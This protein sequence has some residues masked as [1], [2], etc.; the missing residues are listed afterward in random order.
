MTRRGESMT[1]A[2]AAFSDCVASILGSICARISCR[3]SDDFL[4]IDDLG[5]VALSEGSEEV[6]DY[7]SLDA[8]EM[9]VGAISTSECGMVGTSN[10]DS[11]ELDSVC[12]GL[13][14]GGGDRTGEDTL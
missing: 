8:E 11:R 6:H 2:P 13:R 14:R 10:D 12:Q 1:D 3:C 9:V 4:G 7:I 5:F